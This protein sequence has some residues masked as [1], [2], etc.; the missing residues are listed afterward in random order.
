MS[1][2]LRALGTKNSNLSLHIRNEILSLNT[3]DYDGKLG[4]AIENYYPHIS[5]A[6]EIDLQTKILAFTRMEGELLKRA[7]FRGE[8]RK[9]FL[10]IVSDY[11]KCENKGSNYDV[12]NDLNAADLLYICSEVIFIC[13]SKDTDILDIIIDQLADMSGGMCAQGRTHRL[14][15]II[16]A[17]VELLPKK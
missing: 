1:K 5:K 12:S 14:M 15:G 11:K 13:Q 17:L 6:S 16:P 3:H 4:I 10:T 2:T 9:N 7:G 8:A